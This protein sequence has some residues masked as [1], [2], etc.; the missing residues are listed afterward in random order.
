VDLHQ[1]VRVTDEPLALPAMSV[2]QARRAQREAVQVA[3]MMALPAWQWAASWL[4]GL[5]MDARTQLL[6]TPP[7]EIDGQ[8]QIVAGYAMAGQIA[9]DMLRR[10]LE[11]NAVLA[12]AAEEPLPEWSG[13]EYDDEQVTKNLAAMRSAVA[14]VEHDGWK[15]LMREMAARSRAHAALLNGCTEREAARHMSAILSIANVTTKMQEIL[16]LGADTE[17]Y[18]RVCAER[19][20]PEGD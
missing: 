15:L 14:L 17:A 13:T 19:H 7:A 1:A 18:L 3:E 20:E 8:Q 16:D 10:T 5:E 2:E 4:G 11:A 9:A 6:N 12:N